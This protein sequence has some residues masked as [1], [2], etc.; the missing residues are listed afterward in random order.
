[1]QCLRAL[2]GVSMARTAATISEVAAGGVNE[3]DD[4]V[5]A[6]AKLVDVFA[7]KGGNEGL[8][9]LGEDSV[10][11]F[12]A[13]V[14]EG[15]DDLHLLGHAGVVREHFEKGVGASIDIDGLFGEEVKETLFARQE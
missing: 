6:A 13:F 10:S 2:S 3:V 8:V 1:M 11:D 4:V 14:L 15:F 9:Q 12:V 5:E 7:I